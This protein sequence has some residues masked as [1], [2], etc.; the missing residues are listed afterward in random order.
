[1]GRVMCYLG[2]LILWGRY[3]SGYPTMLCYKRCC[4][5]M[6]SSLL[7][8]YLSF[9]LRINK[10]ALDKILPVTAFFCLS[11]LALHFLYFGKLLLPY[12]K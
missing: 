12:K 7:S 3:L 2:K 4:A 10:S 8:K 11:F 1:M 6:N 9:Q 5:V